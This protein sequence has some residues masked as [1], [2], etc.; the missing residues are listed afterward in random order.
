MRDA[1]RDAANNYRNGDA[2]NQRYVY[3]GGQPEGEG[4]RN[5]Y[6]NNPQYQTD[7]A[8]GLVDESFSPET[9][10]EM[11]GDRQAKRDAER[12]ER[13][14]VDAY[15]Q[16]YQEVIE[17]GGTDREAEIAGTQA[18]EAADNSD[19]IGDMFRDN[20]ENND[21]YNEAYGKA[22]ADA[23]SNGMSEREAEAAAME[24]GRQAAENKAYRMT[25]TERMRHDPGYSYVPPALTD[26][27]RRFEEEE[28]AGR[29]TTIVQPDDREINPDYEAARKR[30]EEQE[31]AANGR[32]GAENALPGEMGEGTGS[33]TQQPNTTPNGGTGTTPQGGTQQPGTTSGTDTTGKGNGGKNVPQGSQY[34][35]PSYGQGGQVVKAPYRKG[36]YTAEELKAMG[37]HAY[38][39]KYG[40]ELYEGYYM[41]PDGAYYPVDQAKANYWR[42]NGGSYKGWEEGM[43]DYYNTFGTFYGYRPGWQSAGRVG[44]GGGGYS[45]GGGGGG[46]SAKSSSKSSSGSSSGKNYGSGSSVNNGLYWNGNTSWN[47]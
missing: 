10:E 47:I 44:G 45:Y 24:A 12:A 19:P 3:R 6:E 17:N 21:A 1:E 7:L 15:S 20:Q 4:G 28:A 32:V 40:S 5:T 33:G 42:Q 13:D 25:D 26:A 14:S 9:L 22:Y 27:Q 23:I 8:L 16:A 35:T 2:G 18:V 41:A 29:I 11:Y 31:K 39:K 30:Q 37:N 36:G 46:G 38:G 34:L 43:R